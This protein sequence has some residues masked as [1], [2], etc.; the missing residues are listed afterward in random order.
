MFVLV[1]EASAIPV[2][3]LGESHFLAPSLSWSMDYQMWLALLIQ[4]VT[5]GTT[6][7]SCWPVFC[8][9]YKVGLFCSSWLKSLAF[10]KSEM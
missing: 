8:Y 10:K 2:I 3:S 5:L 7:V 9:L 4:K 1:L 6:E